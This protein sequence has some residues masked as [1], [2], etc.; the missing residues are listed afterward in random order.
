MWGESRVN[1]SIPISA[2]KSWQMTHVWQTWP[3][4]FGKTANV[5]SFLYPWTLIACLL[6]SPKNQSQMLRCHLQ[7][8]I[9]SHSI[10]W[11]HL[12]CLDFPLHPHSTPITSHS[13]VLSIPPFPFF[14]KHTSPRSLGGLLQ[15]WNLLRLRGDPALRTTREPSDPRKTL[16]DYMG[17]VTQ[18]VTIW[19]GE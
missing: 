14:A 5:A 18:V 8:L 9:D 13:L 19:L 17:R 2:G 4:D 6:G 10:S 15:S 7:Y 3:G 12:C 11:S 1:W 16:Q